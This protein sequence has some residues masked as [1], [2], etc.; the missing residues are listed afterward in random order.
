MPGSAKR[1]DADGLGRAN[2]ACA[3]T[4]DNL[5]ITMAAAQQDV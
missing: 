5:D 2:I 3:I 1:V 4:G